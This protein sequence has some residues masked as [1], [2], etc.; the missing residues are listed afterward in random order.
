VPAFPALPAGL[1]PDWFLL[2]RRAASVQQTLEEVTTA[3]RA[4]GAVGG[5]WLRQL[6]D[7]T[8]AAQ[9]LCGM[10]EGNRERRLALTASQAVSFSRGG[11]GPQ[12]EWSEPIKN[13]AAVELVARDCAVVL[14]LRDGGMRCLQCADS[15][16]CA[17]VSSVLDAA[18][19]RHGD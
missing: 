19:K 14:H 17:A 13:I 8:M 5:R 7:G 9:A 11:N 1:R 6:D 18:V 4:R 2:R 15:Q 16:L 12:L 10:M 3:D